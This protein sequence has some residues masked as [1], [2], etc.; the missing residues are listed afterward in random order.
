MT[1]LFVFIP[2]VVL[3]GR[4]IRSGFSRSLDLNSGYRWPIFGLSIILTLTAMFVV[5]GLIFGAKAAWPGASENDGIMVGITAIAVML[6]VLSAIATAHTFVRLRV[7]KEG[8]S[9]EELEDAF[10]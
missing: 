9:L 3:E 10:S 5:F 8:A 7:A 4:G 1:I 2:A 6:G